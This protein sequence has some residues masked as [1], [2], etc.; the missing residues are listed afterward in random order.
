MYSVFQLAKKYFKYYTTASNGRG[1]GVHSPFVYEFIT[2][3]LQ[4]K[5]SNP[6]FNKIEDRRKDL[7]SDKSVIQIEDFGAGSAVLPFKS[8][9]V[10]QTAKVSLKSKKYSQLLFKI[11]KYFQAKTVVELGTSFGITT[12]YLASATYGK[13]YT[14]EGAS[15][16]ANIARQTFSHLNLTQI[17]IIQGD[18]AKTLT[19]KLQA[20]GQVDI[21]FLDGNHRKNPTIEYFNLFKDHINENSILIF[22]DIHWSKGMEE[23]WEEIK[24][25]SQ[26][27]LTIDLFFIGLVFFRKNFKE[28]QH[29]TIRF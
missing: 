21:A 22:D 26:V 17:D 7:L 9:V 29:F 20:I 12:S 24:N 27:T 25:D 3:V 10:G 15:S 4:D 13:V 1:H 16:I 23:A 28:K 8:R 5:S 14:F 6:V 11:V 19:N 2:N 18:F